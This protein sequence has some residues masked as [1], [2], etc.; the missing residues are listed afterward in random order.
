MGLRGPLRDPHSQRGRQEQITLDE[1]ELPV[2]PKWLNPAA[3]KIFR[4]L[5]EDLAAAKVPLKRV[6]GYAISMAAQCIQ[7]TQEWAEK[8]SMTPPPSVDWQKDC[9]ALVA[10]FERDARDWLSVIGGHVKSRAQIGLRGGSQPKP[11]GPLA[12]IDKFRSA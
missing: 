10:R 7:Q 2:C 5:V 12:V 3:K 6:D 9:A 11:A 1:P 4:S 8:Q